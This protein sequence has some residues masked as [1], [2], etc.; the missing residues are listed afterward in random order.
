MRIESANGKR[1][2][3]SKVNIWTAA[4]PTTDNDWRH[5]HPLLHLMAI[6]KT[7]QRNLFDPNKLHSICYPDH[8]LLSALDVYFYATINYKQVYQDHTE[9]FHFEWKSTIK[10]KTTR[11]TVTSWLIAMH[12]RWLVWFQLP[13]LY[14]IVVLSSHLNAESTSFISVQFKDV[15]MLCI[16]V[17]KG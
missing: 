16:W 6:S 14:M 3:E 12:F 10:L 8:I 1:S 11:C 5:L 17:M 13:S 15:D 9:Q 7:K 4:L 2:N